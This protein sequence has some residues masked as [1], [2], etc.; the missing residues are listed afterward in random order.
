[1]GNID[2]ILIYQYGREENIG[3]ILMLIFA[4]IAISTGYQC[5]A[6]FA[7]LLCLSLVKNT[8]LPLKKI[9]FGNKL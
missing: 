5:E 2:V 3:M 4:H 6:F 9:T 7:L 8:V 1:M